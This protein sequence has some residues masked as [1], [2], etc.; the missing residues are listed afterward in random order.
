MCFWFVSTVPRVRRIGASL[1][2]FDLGFF[3]DHG[4]G[5][6]PS[7]ATDSFKPANC[8]KR[9]VFTLR[10]N[11][12]TRLRNMEKSTATLV[13]SFINGRDATT[14]LT[15]QRVKAVHR[16]LVDDA[17]CSATFLARSGC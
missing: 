5:R 13:Q 7:S 12:S 15:H 9:S 10:N 1:L 2:D 14:D 6:A 3:E 17:R 16:S 4:K 8:T 11:I